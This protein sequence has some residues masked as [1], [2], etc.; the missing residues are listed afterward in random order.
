MQKGGALFSRIRRHSD[1][2][3]LLRT[4]EG[5]STRSDWTLEESTSG[6]GQKKTVTLHTQNPKERISLYL[7]GGLLH[8]LGGKVD[9]MNS[10][11]GPS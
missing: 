11:S 5:N 4:S 8:K 1:E 7:G 10:S 2:N 3:K 9:P 6:H